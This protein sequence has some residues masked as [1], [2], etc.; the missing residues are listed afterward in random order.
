MP[1]V[2]ASQMSS[3]SV[4]KSKT[5]NNNDYIS[6]II[7][8]ASEDTLIENTL[9]SMHCLYHVGTHRFIKFLETFTRDFGQ[10]W[11]RSMFFMASVS[12]DLIAAHP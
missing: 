8:V 5:V 12:A 3:K 10:Y 4:F 2:I 11:H 9:I 6:C 7:I 1:N